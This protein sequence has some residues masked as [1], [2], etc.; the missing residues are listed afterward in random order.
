[1]T[2]FPM[3]HPF[4]GGGATDVIVVQAFSLRLQ[5]KRLHDK[6]SRPHR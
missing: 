6:H 5:L 4:R 2:A 1:M 3:T